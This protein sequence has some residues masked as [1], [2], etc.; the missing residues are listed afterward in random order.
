MSTPTRV[1][2]DVRSQPEAT[3]YTGTTATEADGAVT[4][5]IFRGDGSAFATDA[6]TTDVDPDVGLYRYTLAAQANLERFRFVWEGSFSSIVNRVTTHVEIVGGYIVSLADIKAEVGMS[7]KTDPQLAEARTWFEDL[8]ESW[9]GVAFV[10]RY[11]R[12]VLDGDGS[13]RVR[14]S[15]RLPR[16]I[17][18]AKIDGTAQTT[19]GWGLYDDGRVVA[20]NV[21]FPVGRRNIE[22]IYEHG[23]DAPEAEVREAALVAIRS[24]LASGTGSNSGLP[25]GVTQLITDAGTMIFGRKPTGPFAIQEVNDALAMFRAPMVA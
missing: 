22:V 2:R 21:H 8:A 13:S 5:D 19:T 20:D 1:L 14:L 23:Y 11:G 7:A 15:H 17:L 6:S 12:D 24:K 10:P 9:C 16:T 18:S 3:F 25:S 4:V